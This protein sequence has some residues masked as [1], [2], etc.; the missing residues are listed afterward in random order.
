MLFIKL[1]MI[2]QVLIYNYAGNVGAKSNMGFFSSLKAI[3]SQLDT[4]IVVDP[5]GTP[6]EAIIILQLIFVLIDDG[7]YIYIN[8]STNGVKSS[9]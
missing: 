9:W 7:E 3:W 5:A 2:C 6:F 1:M 8:K 4:M